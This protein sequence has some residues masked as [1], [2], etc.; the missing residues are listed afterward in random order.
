MKTDELQIIA[1][2]VWLKIDAKLVGIKALGML[3][4]A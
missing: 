3:S 1:D 4:S 2:K